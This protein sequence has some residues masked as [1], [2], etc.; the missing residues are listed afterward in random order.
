MLC[1]ALKAVSPGN[2]QIIAE[3]LLLPLILHRAPSPD[4]YQLASLIVEFTSAEPF[5]KYPLPDF[6]NQEMPYAIPLLAQ[7]LPESKMQPVNYLKYLPHPYK[8]VTI[9]GC[10]ECK[11]LDEISNQLL[12]EDA[13]FESFE[14]ADE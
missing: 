14:G 3:C 6:T 10:I 1:S 2:E 4:G 12:T 8:L 13:F 11:S 9:M 7:I 5:L